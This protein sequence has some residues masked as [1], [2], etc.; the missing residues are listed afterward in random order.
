LCWRVDEE[1]FLKKYAADDD[2]AI[3]PEIV[4]PKPGKSE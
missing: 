2:I 3:I 1:F 4:T